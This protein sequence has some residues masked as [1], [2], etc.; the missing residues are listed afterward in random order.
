[1]EWNDIKAFLQSPIFL[2]NQVNSFK[3]YCDN[4]QIDIASVA[5]ANKL[6][7]PTQAEEESYSSEAFNALRDFVRSAINYFLA[8]QKEYSAEDLHR[9]EVVPANELI[10]TPENKHMQKVQSQ[11]NQP[12]AVN[13]NKR[14]KTPAVSNTTANTRPPISQMKSPTSLSPPRDGPNV[15]PAK[16]ETPQESYK[17]TGRTSPPQVQDDVPRY[18]QQ[19]APQS[20]YAQIQGRA[21]IVPGFVT[22]ESK[23]QSKAALNKSYD[24]VRARSREGPSSKNAYWELQRKINK[25]LDEKSHRSATQTPKRT[26]SRSVVHPEDKDFLEELTVR[27]KLEEESQEHRKAAR[28]YKQKIAR[29]LIDH[30]RKVNYLLSNS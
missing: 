30:E 26:F 17:E 21:Q 5:R 25:A 4:K 10:E 20:K 13:L 7:T 28:N 8:T 2:V 22:P 9:F 12:Q 1:M 3:D 29:L 6:I 18:R 19:Q 11:T 15:T 14:A 16:Y 27:L 24:E 23:P